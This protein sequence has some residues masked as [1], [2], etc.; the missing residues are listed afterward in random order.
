M[1]SFFNRFLCRGAFFL[2]VL[3]FLSTAVFSAVPEKGKKIESTDPEQ[4]LAWYKQHMEMKEKSPFK[5]LEWRFLGPDVI[6]GRCTDIAVPK[7]EKHT[8]YIGAATGGVWKTENSGIT[9]ESLFDE[10]SSISIGDIAI[11]QVNPDIIWVGTGEA[12]IFRA[13]VA[14]TGVYKST[15]AGKTWEHMGFADTQ[16]IGRIV[17]HPE[18]PDIVYV[19][20]SGHEW[21]YNE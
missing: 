21:A 19:G 11:A 18:N 15:D 13:S 5:D 3:L 7:G 6:S 9:W 4:R 8:V 17:I 10:A 20:A 2:V 14:G 16:T 1:S 12:N